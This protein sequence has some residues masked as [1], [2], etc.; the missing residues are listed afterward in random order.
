MVCHEQ[1]SK[2][3]YQ[4]LLGSDHEFLSRVTRLADYEV[5]D[6]RFPWREGMKLNSVYDFGQLINTIFQIR[7]NLFQ[8]N[9]CLDDDQSTLRIV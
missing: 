8:S 2:K 7:C 5:L 3:S 6:M 9:K 4:T 1:G